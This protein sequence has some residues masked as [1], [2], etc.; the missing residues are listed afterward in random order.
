MFDLNVRWLVSHIHDRLLI[1]PELLIRIYTLRSSINLHILY[2]I[3]THITAYMYGMFQNLDPKSVTIFTFYAIFSTVEKK[4]STRI[5]IYT[6][7]R[8]FWW[9]IYCSTCNIKQDIGCLGLKNEHETQNGP[10]FWN[11][12]YVYSN[13]LGF[14]PL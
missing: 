6:K 11:V 14:H 8:S 13:P 12:P 2:T 7:L 1:G 9:L 5:V 10:R 4:V 3:Y